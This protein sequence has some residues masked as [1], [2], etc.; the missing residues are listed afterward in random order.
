MIVVVGAGPCGLF[1]ASRLHDLGHD[2]LVLSS[3]QKIFSFKNPKLKNWIQSPGPGGRAKLWGGW[4]DFPQKE[5]FKKEK[6]PVSFNQLKKQE[7]KVRKW[8]Q[9][10]KQYTSKQLIHL[11][12]Q[13]KVQAMRT[14]KKWPFKIRQNIQV[15]QLIEKNNKMIGLECWDEKK[16]VNFQINADQII[17]CC[18]PFSTISLLKKLKNPPPSLERGMTNHMV[19]GFI[20]LYPKDAKRSSS[21]PSLCYKQLAQGVLELQGPLPAKNLNSQWTNFEYFKFHYIGE[22]SSKRF[23]VNN[24][25][26]DGQISFT[27]KEKSFAKKME[28]QLRQEIDSLKLKNG[29]KYKIQNTL[30]I[31]NIAHESGGAVLSEVVR[32]DGRMKN[33]SNLSVM[34]ASIMPSGLKTYPTLPLLCLISFLIEKQFQKKN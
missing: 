18:S 28:K 21:K 20:A 9:A 30:D 25:V 1:V 23:K 26:V 13:Q 33:Y 34:D 32:L 8:L 6:W 2:V 16:K 15:H 5:N 19:A 29:L 7:P 12:Y 10:K 3:S 22:L 17:L 14:W 11:G 31:T 24:F 4:L 27:D